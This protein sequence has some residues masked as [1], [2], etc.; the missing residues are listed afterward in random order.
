LGF[1]L[2]L[3]S[4]NI[5]AIV[6]SDSESYSGYLKIF[7]A[8]SFYIFAKTA[9]FGFDGAVLAYHQYQRDEGSIATAIGIIMIHSAFLI[10]IVAVNLNSSSKVSFNKIAL[11]PRVTLG[12]FLVCTILTCFASAFTYYKNFYD[13]ENSQSVIAREISAAVSTTLVNTFILTLAVVLWSKE[14]MHISLFVTA[15]CSLRFL[16]IAFYDV[17]DDESVSSG[18][19][20]NGQTVVYLAFASFVTSILTAL[21]FSWIYFE[22]DDDSSQKIVRFCI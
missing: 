18:M 9:S 3:F 20:S 2:G 17:S 8:G 21:P 14:M 22:N 11:N 6:S 16:A 13:D 5:V 12:I 7:I 1:C 4:L 15:L 19:F 10:G